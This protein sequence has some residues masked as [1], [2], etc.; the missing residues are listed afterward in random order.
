MSETPEPAEASGASGTPVSSP[1]SL[2]LVLAALEQA[3]VGLVV[4]ARGDGGLIANRRAAEMC[5]GPVQLLGGVLCLPCRA[6]AL[7]GARADVADLVEAAMSGSSSVVELVLE[8]ASREALRVRLS[9]RPLYQG[10]DGKVL[11][12]VAAIED[13]S[14]LREE[15]R[16]RTEWVSIV[17]HDLR[18]PIQLIELTADALLRRE[19]PLLPPVRGSMELLARKAR[20]LGR[21][22]KDLL[23]VSCVETRRL[24]LQPSR[25]ELGRLV[26]EAARRF[27]ALLPA[28]RSL[29]V[30]V[31]P[32][33]AVIDCDPDRIEQVLTNLITN[34]IRYGR[35]GTPI[36]VD[37]EPCGG[38][39]CL[40]VSNIGAGIPAGDLRQLFARFAR[41]PD[42]ARGSL[43]LGLYIARGIV[44]A[45]GGAIDVESTPGGR[46]TFSI[47]LPRRPPPNRG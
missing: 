25:V 27:E 34:A 24:A 36:E 42:G 13:V 22:V 15:Q 30:T 4:V 21:L 44:E 29:E 14:G 41:G 26:E 5:G 1:A 11:G 20:L 18:T 38:G 19:P 40:A 46:T 33:P 7:D 9:A 10:G 39:A 31:A 32:V 12:A 8:P 23:D 37:V 17:A 47:R 6:R 45:H 2:E 3:P 16:L 43:G 28:G 35:A